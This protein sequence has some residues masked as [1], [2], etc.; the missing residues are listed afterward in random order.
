V[1]QTKIYKEIK[2]L[3]LLQFLHYCT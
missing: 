1:P 2:K 3:R